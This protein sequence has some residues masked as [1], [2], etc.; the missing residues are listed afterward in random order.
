MPASKPS[1]ALVIFIL[2]AFDTITPLTIDMYLPAFSQMA[3]EFGTT[4]ARVSLSLT[5]YFIGLGIGQIFYGPLLDRYGRHKPLYYGMA[6][7]IVACLGCAWSTSAEMFI[8]FRL[9]QALGCCVSAV[10]VRAM[11]RDY[12][13]LQESPKIFS[14]LMLILSVSPLLAPSLGS[15]I[16][17]HL[18]WSWVFYILVIIV[19]LVLV[20]T[21]FYLPAVY[22]PDPSVSLRIAPMVRTYREILT[23]RQFSVYTFATSFSLGGLF[24]Y[25]A[26][27]TIILLEQFKVT[28]AFYAIL[29][30]VQSIGLILGNQLNI[31]LLKKYDANFL[32]KLALTAQMISAL[33]FV[34]GTLLG[35]YE[36]Y[37]TVAFFFVLLTCL[38]M[39]FP[40]G[41]ALALAPF[42]QNIGSA[43][44]LMGFLQIGIG[45]LFSASVGL[46]NPTTSFPIAALL[47]AS[48]VLAWVVLIV[49][50]PTVGIKAY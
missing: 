50:K 38:G 27:S 34:T 14:M 2:G 44:S 41:S 13:T 39:T 3:E 18:H 28:P 24:V 7:Y 37:A 16:T 42:T 33:L 22:K 15:A 23:N 30:A 43:S 40:N 8:A 17:S 11:V 26:G 21:Y 49:G 46:L 45:G 9:V 48:A 36:V 12:F 35:W 31:T 1:R 10:G 29:F 47:A 5:S 4:T 25:L 20:I 6:L 19:V 32:Y